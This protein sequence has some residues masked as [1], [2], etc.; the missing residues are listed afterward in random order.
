MKMLIKRRGL[1]R[2]TAM[3]VLIL[4]LSATGAF[5]ATGGT[6]A[7]SANKA[8][9]KQDI[10]DY[11]AA[12][13][14]GWNLGN[15][16]DAVG[17]GG[18]ADPSAE[19]ET[20]WGNPNVTEELIQQIAAEGFKSI[21][22]PVTWE[23]KMGPAPDYAIQPAYMDRVEEVVDWSLDAGLY[24]MLN[25][26]HDSWRWI[27]GMGDNR[28]DVVNR[29]NAA[30]TQIAEHFKDHPRELMLESINEPQF[31]SPGASGEQ[32]M[33]DALNASF[34][35]IVR[36][37][38][39][40]NDT[41]PLVLPT[42]H[43]SSDQE[44]VDALYDFIADLDDPNLIA[45]V[46]FYGFWPFSVNIAG[47]TTFKEDSKNHLIEQFD[48]VHD[49]YTAEGI[50][51]VIGEYGLLGF[52]QHT[53]TIQQGEKLK[54]FEYMIHYAQTKDLIHMLW[55]NGQHY[56]RRTMEWNDPQLAAMMK[57]SWEG[58]S[59][60][61]ETDL[62][63][64]R[65]GSETTRV[66]IPM[67][68]H[69]QTL[70]DVSI[71]DRVLIAGPEYT[72]YKNRLTFQPGLLQELTADGDYGVN[73]EITARFSSGADWTFQVVLFD[74]P[75]LSA[76]SGT[77]EDFAI[78]AVFNGDQL[79][80]MEAKYEDGSNAGPQ[81]WTSFKEFSYTF[82]PDYEEGEIVL[83]PNFFKETNDGTVHLTFYF[84][85]G[86]TLEYTLTKAGDQVTGT[87]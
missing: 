70:V 39:G 69:G 77:T 60:T 82:E 14:P 29:Y 20:A 40:D 24:V 87:P 86:E 38:G 42:M 19:D 62:I 45:T 79:A 25:L 36:N 6:Q 35:D 33:L 43:T 52:D 58:R 2:M 1:A 41:R 3:I 5:A 54:F 22:I 63:F 17:L 44:H 76:T 31:S 68:V 32:E 51:V 48:R 56:N 4:S 73:A 28:A 72:Y 18:S 34:Y 30:W 67:D 59:V 83:K 21:R 80:T 37:S 8:T 26:H 27:N 85:S 64:V 57:A 55:D 10:A 9:A 65:E 12:M 74:A 47:Y 75:E 13:Q 46:H 11:A 23:H 81:N 78:P 53:G 71:G 7:G 66:L 49:K 84:W 61:G 16:F 50:P 15:T